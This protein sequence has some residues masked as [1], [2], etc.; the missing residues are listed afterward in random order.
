LL[1]LSHLCDLLDKNDL[2]EAE[3]HLLS[4]FVHG[5]RKIDDQAELLVEIALLSESVK[6]SQHIFCRHPQHI[7][8]FNKKY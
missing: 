5:N 4:F 3:L 1:L 7:R 6:K 8:N 2:K